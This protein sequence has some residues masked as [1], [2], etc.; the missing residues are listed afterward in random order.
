MNHYE[1]STKIIKEEEEDPDLIIKKPG[2]GVGEK[3]FAD[4]PNKIPEEDFED[5]D[6]I[7]EIQDKYREEKKRKNMK[8]SAA[9]KNNQPRFN[10]KLYKKEAPG[11]G[12]YYDGEED[13]WNK[14]TY[15]ILFADI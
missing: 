8:P 12:A 13:N 15:N 14:R 3:R 6:I 9:F 10:E 4:M 1:L 2:F 7:K 11:P 5:D